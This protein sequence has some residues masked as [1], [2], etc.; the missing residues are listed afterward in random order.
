METISTIAISRSSRKMLK[1]IGSKGQTYDEIIKDLI[2]WKDQDSPDCKVGSLQ[3]SESGNPSNLAHPMSQDIDSAEVNKNLCDGNGC[4]R[5]A[6]TEIEVNVGELGVIK[7]NL[8]ENCRPKFI[9]SI[10][11]ENSRTPC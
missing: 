3:S 4:I 2:K 5:K 9:Q 1:G 7:L 8:C 6:T 10:T 11:N